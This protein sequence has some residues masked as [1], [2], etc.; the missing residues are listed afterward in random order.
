MWTPF[1][2]AALTYGETPMEREGPFPAVE[3]G[4]GGLGGHTQVRAQPWG[5]Q[6][7]RPGAAAHSSRLG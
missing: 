5:Q 3:V 4:D 7:H 1:E 6:R 2:R